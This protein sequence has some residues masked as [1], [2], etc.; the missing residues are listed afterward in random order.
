MFLG[1]MHLLKKD[2]WWAS[3]LFL[4]FGVSERR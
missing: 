3:F 1:Q 2:A 4:A